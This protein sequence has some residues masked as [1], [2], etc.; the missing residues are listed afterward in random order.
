MLKKL[1]SLFL[2]F[3]GFACVN[4]RKMEEQVWSAA[5]VKNTLANDVV[6]ISLYVDD[7]KSLP[8]K[9]QILVKRTTG[10]GF[11]KLKNYGP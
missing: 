9:E 6:L 3:T 8:E 10:D 5:H 7:K 2:D 1:I 4:C 11:R